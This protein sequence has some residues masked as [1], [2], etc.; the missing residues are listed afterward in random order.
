MRKTFAFIVSFAIC[1]AIQ[2]RASEPV[3]F[4]GKSPESF[5]EP[6]GSTL[7]IL[8]YWA[9]YCVPCKQEMKDLSRLYDRYRD[10][11]LLVVGVSVDDA[12]KGTLVGKVTQALGVGYPIIY[13]LASSFK[14]RTITGLPT[15]FILDSKGSILEEIEGKRS[16]EAFSDKVERHLATAASASTSARLNSNALEDV[17]KVFF[18]VEASR[19]VLGGSAVELRLRPT[20]DYHLN[21]PGYPSLSLILDEAAKG[22]P[23]FASPVKLGTGGV[24]EGEQAIWKITVDAHVSRL[25]GSLKAIVCGDSLCRPVEERFQVDIR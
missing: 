19:L 23:G 7:V 14:G 3:D 2:L 16:F 6:L 17:R 4:S 22:E 13:G 21:G 11:G 5:F 18:T 1:S 24:R 15:T 9:T 20:R 10:R 12:T 25:S 8:N